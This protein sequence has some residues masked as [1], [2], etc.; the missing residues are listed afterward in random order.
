M[1][2]SRGHTGVV[3]PVPIPNTEV[4]HSRADGTTWVTAWESRTLRGL[5]Q[6]LGH[7]SDRGFLFFC[8]FIDLQA[9]IA[10][11][12]KEKGSVVKGRAT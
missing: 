9:L 7:E 10:L 5:N 8:G 1:K 11:N 4:K 3:T 12:C 2:L 6:T